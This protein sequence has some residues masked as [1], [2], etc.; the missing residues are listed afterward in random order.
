[1]KTRSILSVFVCAVI[2][3]FTSSSFAG[4]QPRYTLPD[5]KPAPNQRTQST[6]GITGCNG[7]V[8]TIHPN[9]LKTMPAEACVVSETSHLNFPCDENGNAASGVRNK[10]VCVKYATRNEKFHA[11]IEV[12]GRGAGKIIL[13]AAKTREGWAERHELLATGQ[14][15]AVTWMSDRA[16]RQYASNGGDQNQVVIA[17]GNN[18]PSTQSAPVQQAKADCGHLSFPQRAA[19]EIGNNAGL[20]AAIGA[21]VRAFGK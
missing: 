13:V 19:C 18:T 12:G 16:S 8:A 2:F 21:G 4:G 14:N 10:W 5:G 6:N 17:G 3:A 7:Y 1:M 9:L 11:V 20:G 15:T